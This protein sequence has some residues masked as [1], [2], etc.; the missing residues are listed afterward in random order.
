VDSGIDFKR[1]GDCFELSGGHIKNAVVRAAYRA[2]SREG[3]VEWADFEFAA[4]QEC[5]NAGKLFRTSAM[6]LLEEW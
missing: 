4:E 6:A 5:K 1:L 3:T 2:A